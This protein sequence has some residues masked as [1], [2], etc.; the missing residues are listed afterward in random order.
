MKCT[1]SLVT[2]ALPNSIQTLAPW[3]T[4]NEDLPVPE[5][6]GLG[7]EV[8]LSTQTQNYIQCSILLIVRARRGP[9]DGFGGVI[10]YP[11]IHSAM[12]SCFSPVPD[13]FILLR[14]HWQSVKL[15]VPFHLCAALKPEMDIF[16]LI[17]RNAS[18]KYLRG[19]YWH[20]FYF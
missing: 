6:W 14:V 9:L 11:Q 3:H 7:N 16:P 5:M 8:Q 18:S 15:V 13:S 4:Q 1:L 17:F 20:P 19:L 2:R 10:A 12:S